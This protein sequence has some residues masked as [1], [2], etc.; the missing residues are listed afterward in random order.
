MG[1]RAPQID[2]G[3]LTRITNGSRKDFQLGG[4]D[5]EDD[6]QREGEGNR[7]LVALGDVEPRVAQVRVLEVGRQHLFA[8][9]PPGTPRLGPW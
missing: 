4:K 8:P 1:S 3:T 5:E 9:A 2:I 7:Q 6:H